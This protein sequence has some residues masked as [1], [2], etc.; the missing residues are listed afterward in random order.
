MFLSCPGL[1]LTLAYSGGDKFAFLFS[2]VF[3]FTQ[4]LNLGDVKEMCEKGRV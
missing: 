1:P 2:S 3:G 4:L